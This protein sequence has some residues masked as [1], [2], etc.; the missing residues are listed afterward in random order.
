MRVLFLTDSLSDLDGV[1]RYGVRL[2][3]ALER[4]EPG[5]QVEILLARKH[6]P[7]SSAVPK[8][9]RVRVG[10]PPDYFFH[11]S[12]PKFWP[13]FLGATWN[14]AR[15]ARGADLVHAIKDYPHNFAGAWG[16]RLAGVPC[17]ATAHGTYSV[18]P[19]LDPRHARRARWTYRN[20]AGLISVSRYTAR[21]LEALLGAHDLPAGGIVVIPNAVFAEHYES[22]PELSQVPPW[23]GKEFTLG[24]GELKERKGHHLALEA[25]LAAAVRFPA[26]HHFVVGKS[27]GDSYHARLVAM[28]RAAGMSE[29]VH[30]LGNVGESEK[31]DLLR[32]AQLFLHTPVTAAGGGFEGF[33]IVYLEAAAAGIPSIGTL[34]CGAEDA[35]VDGVTGRLVAQDPRAVEAALGQLLGDAALRATLGAQAREHARRSPW[36]DNAKRVLEL[37]RSALGGPR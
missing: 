21:R 22:E 25:W 29:R 4:L 17:I 19:L 32:R 1:G 15:A 23:H 37:Y 13:S 31:I 30:F 24:I 9:W 34:E 33:G 10:L 27:S 16:A 28:A 5:L 3:E 6:R 18:Q 2:I 36:E 35:I 11:M 8:H 14:V 7:T 26:L 20:L 12:A